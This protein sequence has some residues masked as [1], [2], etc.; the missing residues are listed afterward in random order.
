MARKSS[1]LGGRGCVMGR[2]INIMLGRGSMEGGTGSMEGGTGSMEGGTGSMEGANAQTLV[3][4]VSSAVG[5]VRI[6]AIKKGS[7]EV[8]PLDVLLK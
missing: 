2:K 3:V 8:L 6:K 5:S 1:M 4:R 7:T